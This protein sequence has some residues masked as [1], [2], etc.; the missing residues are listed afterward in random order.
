VVEVIHVHKLWSHKETLLHMIRVIVK[1]I[2]HLT[3]SPK[4][5][6]HNLVSL[7]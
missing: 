3:L 6:C 5:Y 4:T 1:I 7:K 2:P